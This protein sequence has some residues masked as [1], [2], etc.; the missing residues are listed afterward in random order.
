MWS[1]QVANTRRSSGG[2]PLSRAGFA[3]FVRCHVRQKATCVCFVPEQKEEIP[4]PVLFLSARVLGMRRADLSP[5]ALLL[6]YSSFYGHERHSNFTGRF[7][8]ISGLDLFK[9]TSS[10]PLGWVS[11]PGTAFNWS[12]LA[13]ICG[14]ENLLLFSSDLMVHWLCSLDHHN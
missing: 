2:G 1:E 12:Q 9:F 8:F 5:Q 14:C 3:R 6:L 7:L 13:A 4:N 10:H 11:N